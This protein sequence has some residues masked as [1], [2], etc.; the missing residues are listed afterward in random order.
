MKC[1]LVF[2]GDGAKGMLFVGACSD[3]PKVNKLMGPKK[4]NPVLGLLI[5]EELPVTKTRVR[6]VDPG[7]A[8]LLAVH[9]AARALAD[10]SLHGERGALFRALVP[11][12]A[13]NPTAA[14]TVLSYLLSRGRA[15]P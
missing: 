10:H 6:V 3:P 14:D 4:N 9:F 5:E 15:Q 7:F 13:S 8:P 1:D 12:A 2:E 11:V